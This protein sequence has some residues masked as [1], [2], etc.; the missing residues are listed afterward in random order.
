MALSSHITSDENRATSDGIGRE[1]AE[2]GKIDGPADAFYAVERGFW[3][4]VK[5]FFD[6]SLDRG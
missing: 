2:S 1:T 3:T 5:I 6:F 4:K